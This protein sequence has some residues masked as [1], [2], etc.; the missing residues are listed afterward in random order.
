LIVWKHQREFK[1]CDDTILLRYARGLTTRQIPDQ[2][3]EI[4]AVEGSLELIS[5]ATDKVKE[6]VSEW[7]GWAMVLFL[8][9]LLVHSRDGATMVKQSVYWALV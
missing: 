8:D 3:K 1:R 6:L 4:Y 5:Q 2:F 7:R 9:A